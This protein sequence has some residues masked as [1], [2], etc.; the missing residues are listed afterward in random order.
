MTGFE[1]PALELI[2]YPLLK[3]HA[4][5]NNVKKANEAYSEIDQ[6]ARH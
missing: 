5:Q 4:P 3:H 2:P 6:S 1:N